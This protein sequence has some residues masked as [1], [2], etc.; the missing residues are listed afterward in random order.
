M[1][2]AARR[3][4]TVDSICQRRCLSAT[5]CEEREANETGMTRQ[6]HRQVEQ[7]SCLSP[8]TPAPRAA[9]AAARGCGR[10]TATD[11]SAAAWEATR[12]GPA[13]QT[14][15]DTLQASATPVKP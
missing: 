12:A 7:G 3:Q 4:R 9:L 11:A 15:L 8:T 1:R 13:K 5:G 14:T 6:T 10:S 2:T